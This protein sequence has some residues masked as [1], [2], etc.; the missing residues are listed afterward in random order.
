MGEKTNEFRQNVQKRIHLKVIK[1]LRDWMKTYWDDDFLH[2]LELQKELAL[3][4]QDLTKQ[5]KQMQKQC[6]WIAPLSSMVNK[7]Y[8]RFK[9]KSPNQQARDNALKFNPQTGVPL[10]L[11]RVPI[12][13][14][15]KLSN[16]TA[17]DLPD[18]I[19]VM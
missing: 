15:Y 6:P 1:S 11:E 17:E 8:E 2:D 10:T 14:G 9:L 4:L 5:S 3:W 18:Q 19:T 12:K 7:E 13:K 16:T